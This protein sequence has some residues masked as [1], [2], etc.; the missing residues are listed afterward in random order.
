[1]SNTGRDWFT[2]LIAAV[3]MLGA[4]LLIVFG[5]HPGGSQAQ[6]GW[7]AGL[8]P[9]SIV[10]AMLTGI[11]PQAQ[12]SVYLSSLAIFSFLWYFVIAY[13]VVRLVRGLARP[14]KA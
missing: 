8:L 4:A 5:L 2:A 1:M 12:R 13:V 7:Y 3:L 11:A 10:G 6:V 14:R 9:G